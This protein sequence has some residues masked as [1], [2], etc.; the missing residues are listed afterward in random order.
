MMAMKTEKLNILLLTR[1]L[2]DTQ[3]LFDNYKYLTEAM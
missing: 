3:I 1:L 2:T